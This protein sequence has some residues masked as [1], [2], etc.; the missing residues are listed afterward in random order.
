MLNTEVGRREVVGKSKLYPRALPS[1]I[2]ELCLPV[3][4]GV[5]KVSEVAL[6][7][8]EKKFR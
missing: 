6:N 3:E 5:V 4:E 7:H 1:K 8:V 2:W